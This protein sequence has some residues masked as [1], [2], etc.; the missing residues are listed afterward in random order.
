MMSV[1]KIENGR[2]EKQRIKKLEIKRKISNCRKKKFS[3]KYFTKKNLKTDW[4]EKERMKE[5]I[6]KL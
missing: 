4:K 3:L 5:K 2:V 1:K 6:G